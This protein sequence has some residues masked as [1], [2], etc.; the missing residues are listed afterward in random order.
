MQQLVGNTATV[1]YLEGKEGEKEESGDGDAV[2]T[3]IR[4]CTQG[5]ADAI[6]KS[7]TAGGAEANP[8]CGR[9]TESE[10][11]KQA[12]GRSVTGFKGSDRLPEYSDNRNLIAGFLRASECHIT[13]TIMTKY[14]T[15][16]SVVEGG[17]VA[18][19]AAPLVRVELAKN[20][21]YKP[22]VRTLNAD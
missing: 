10:A 9:P 13:I 8:A 12:G 20:S 11:R 4:G 3:L 18:F 5:Q 14:L 22:G 19:H 6:Q 15:R 7:M 21:A 2:V 17:W 1:K 16:G